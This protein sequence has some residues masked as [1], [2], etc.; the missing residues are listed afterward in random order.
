MR[1]SLLASV[2]IAF[3]AQCFATEPVL[4][5]LF[6]GDTGHHTPADRMRDIAPVMQSHGIQLVY[7][8][9]VESLRLDN[10]KRYDALLIY[11]NIAK[12]SPEQDNAL[13]SYV[14]EGGGL[15]ALHCASYCF[16][17]SPTY[18]SMV[19]A[20]FKSHK[21]GIVK[22]TIIAADNPVMQGFKGFESWDETY[23][24][25]K[26]NSENRTLLEIRGD[27]PWTW[28]RT[29]GKGRVFYTAWGH[30]SR[31]W[32]NPGFQDLVERGIRFCAG[33]KLPDAL[34]QRPAVSSLVLKDQAGIPYYI[35]GKKS[36][37]DGVW[38]QM[39]LP[40]SPQESMQHLV[41][42]AGFEVQL[43]ANDP[44]IKKPI[45]MAWDERG[46]LWIAETL[47]YPN[48]L[49]APGEKGRDRIVICESTKGDWHMDKFTVFADG[50]NIPTGFTFSH[51]G[52]IVN[53]MPNTLFLKDTTGGDHADLKEIL[54]S[55]WGRKDTHAGPS[56]LHYGLD[57]QIW[58]M[59]GYSG[60]S[61]TVG[62]VYHE[63]AQGFSRFTPDG[64]QLEYIRA[65]N[66]NTWGLGFRED[67][68]I[69]GSTANNNP[70]VYMPIANRFYLAAG[71]EPKTLGG[72]ADTSR[73]LPM[74][75]KVRQVDVHWGYTAA[76]GHAFY[77]ARA[78]PKEYWN[79][80]A[81]V[82]EPTGHLVGQFNVTSDGADFHSTNPTNLIS[83]DDEW[84]APIMA[85]VGPDGS[86]WIIDWYNYIVQHNPLPKGFEMGQGNAYEN[87]LR[88]KR[89][90]R[91]YRIVWKGDKGALPTQAMTLAGATPE[92]LVKTL[93]N[94]NLLWRTHAQRL[95]VERGRKDV[96][97]LLIALVQ[98]PKQDEIGLNV[99]VIHA[100]WTLHGL[101]VLDSDAAALQAAT[102]ALRHAS[103]AVRRNA[104]M[105]L[106][107][108]AAGVRAL[109]SAKLLQDNDPQVRLATLL[110]LA[111]SPSVP[112]AGIQLH[113]YLVSSKALDHWMLDAV[114]MAAT[115]QSAGFIASA[116]DVEITAA[117][118]QS[119]GKPPVIEVLAHVVVSKQVS[120]VAGVGSN[121]LVLRLGV[122]PD[123]M[124]YDRTEIT[125][126]AGT[127]VDLV[128]TNNDH[129]QH[130]I[131][132]L[133]P[134]STE[135]VG[136]LID[137]MLTDPQGLAK[138]Y[139]PRTTD[140]LFSLP[141][142]DPGDA[143]DLIFTAPKQAGRYPIVCSFPG[144]WR[145]MQA[146]LVVTP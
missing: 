47:D 67:G 79:K 27:E 110:A 86:V 74:T 131:L 88:D 135:K 36:M 97:P 132:I 105:V 87:P 37:G 52:I 56:N 16:Q 89:Y 63:F 136:A 102:S 122:I 57:N 83:S 14:R 80:V 42:P 59:V 111:E 54:F 3:V 58:S 128:F 65:T 69:F 7:T 1:L 71:L 138:S 113:N 31:T 19:G 44:D 12:I 53:Q 29:E 143:S 93:T 61:G 82:A 120:A 101:H 55:G 68:T 115:A 112:L 109:L 114:K 60:Y 129:M 15:F 25:T 2:Y 28:I 107:R 116:S 48:K 76:A 95:L 11:A 140:M 99:G 39:Q 144:H 62:G 33:E 104:I 118:V 130:N 22:T 127:K 9:D 34:R 124:K 17:N 40:L 137:A 75:S 46:R 121:R 90:G 4:K 141:L 51:G 49:L 41:V 133:K 85:E 45:A 145:M 23:V 26:H 92:L 13:T 73:Y 30:D 38:P 81:F 126:K 139:R 77:T 66:N 125:V 43:V 106:P 18:I 20:Q 100:L 146:T 78:Y 84:F 123:V 21:T 94:N 10:L 96:V 98:D 117:K 91:I 119:E 24:H 142:I 72:I 35:P 103:A 5:V 108:S 8:E 134:D 70:S 64:S 32:T 50:L 6:L